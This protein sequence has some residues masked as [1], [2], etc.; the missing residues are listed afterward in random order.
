MR[1]TAGQELLHECLEVVGIENSF[2]SIQA[3]TAHRVTHEFENSVVRRVGQIA[4]RLAA[5]FAPFDA[6]EH[7]WDIHH[8]GPHPRQLLFSAGAACGRLGVVSRFDIGDFSSIYKSLPEQALQVSNELIRGASLP[9][10]PV[11]DLGD[12][13]LCAMHRRRDFRLCHAEA[14]QLEN[15]VLDVHAS[16]I[17]V[18]I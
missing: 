9:D 12:G 6:S 8:L 4:A 10:L 17:G 14:L 11:L 7:G 1:S 15:D 2:A 18:P 16:S 3:I 5:G 13:R